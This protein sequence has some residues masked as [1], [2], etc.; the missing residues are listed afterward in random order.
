MKLGLIHGLIPNIQKK[1]TIDFS[2][3]RSYIFD[4]AL[5]NSFCVV[6]GSNHELNSYNYNN[7]SLIFNGKLSYHNDT[8]TNLKIHK[9]HFL[10]SSSKDG[11]IAIWD[12]RTSNRDPS[13]ILMAKNRKPLLSFDIN[14]SDTLLA[15]GTELV[16]KD[17]S[18]LFW[19]LRNPSSVY[20]EFIESHNDD[21]TQV[22]FHPISPTQL[23]TG[24]VD[25]LICNFNLNSFKE[26]KDLVGVINSGSSINRAGYFGN[27]EYVYCL[28]HNET[29]SLWGAPEADLLCDF[30]DIRQNSDQSLVRI[31][32]AIDCQFDLSTG[33]L[34]LF[35]GSN[36]GDISMIHVNAN[37]LQLCQTFNGA[38]S[39]IVRSIC[40]NPQTN[41]F[42]TGG[43][44]SKLCLWGP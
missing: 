2:S 38:H 30:G 5:N 19:D 29:F 24:S 20:A 12:L 27:A 14:I 9:D 1:S 21:I 16:A 39:E 26:D 7:N 32:Y 40:W 3:N 15:A 22:K 13:Q 43:E 10:M 42:L 25:G 11:R 17:A 23:I 33:R 41:I 8:I 34:Y 31:D 4:I 18:I 28:T 37:E 36:T 44:D 6:S 35:T